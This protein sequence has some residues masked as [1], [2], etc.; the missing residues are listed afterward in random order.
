MHCETGERERELNDRNGIRA[1]G[2][3]VI[4]DL[5]FECFPIK[6]NRTRLDK[7]KLTKQM[8]G[9]H[10]IHQFTHTH[11]IHTRHSTWQVEMKRRRQRKESKR[12]YVEMRSDPGTLFR[13][14]PEN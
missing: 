6:N 5:F 1:G 13:N 12:T 11:D 3:F 8:T 7:G 9:K 14:V 2:A 10:N 4:C